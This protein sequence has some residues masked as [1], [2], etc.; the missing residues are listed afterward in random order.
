MNKLLSSLAILTGVI[1]GDIIYNCLKDNEKKE[2]TENKNIIKCFI[3]TP[4]TGLTEQEILNNLFIAKAKAAK[5]IQKDHPNAVIRCIDSYNPNIYMND[6]KLL[7]Q[8]IEKLSECDYV[9]FTKNWAKSRGCI[10]ENVIAKSYN[11]KS[12]YEK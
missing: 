7:G 1:A 3:S 12:L 10:V 5:L 4:M 9:Y 11:I 8:A 2:N 6:V